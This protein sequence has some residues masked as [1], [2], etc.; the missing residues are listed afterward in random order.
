MSISTQ[1]AVCNYC[2]CL[3]ISS[4]SAIRDRASADLDEEERLLPPVG[5]D[6]RSE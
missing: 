3:F 1:T 5:Q 2:F 4:G 6:R